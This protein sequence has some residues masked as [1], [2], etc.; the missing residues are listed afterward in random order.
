MQAPLPHNLSRAPAPPLR[1]PYL[2]S[3]GQ[4]LSP[5]GCGLT[6]IS[7]LSLPSRSAPEGRWEG[8]GTW[9][10]LVLNLLLHPST[11]LKPIGNM[12]FWAGSQ[13]VWLTSQQHPQPR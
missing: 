3:S 11:L 10:T 13:G 2:L 5:A 12:S 4:N 7:L 8:S 9:E 6:S 1:S